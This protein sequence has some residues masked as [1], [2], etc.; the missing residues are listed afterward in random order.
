MLSE[1]IYFSSDNLTRFL[2]KVEKTN[3]CWLW[4][5]GLGRGGYGKFHFKRKT[6]AAHRISFYFHNG[7]IPRDKVVCH[8]CDNPK[9]VNPDHLW[10]GTYTENMQDCKK[11]G[12]FN[13]TFP[14]LNQNQHIYREYKKSLNRPNKK[15]EFHH[16]QKLKNEDVKEIR[17]LYKK[18]YKQGIIAKK[19]EIHQSNVSD[20]VNYKLWKHI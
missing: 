10:L 3:N 2:S 9:C 1:K 7:I 18:G 11:K 4:K 17:S 14:V 13:G 8:S 6:M 19:Y 12:R 20:I 5:G 16:L 15:G